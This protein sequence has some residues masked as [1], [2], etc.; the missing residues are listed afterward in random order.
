MLLRVIGQT[1]SAHPGQPIFCVDSSLRYNYK[2][3]RVYFSSSLL[4]CTRQASALR[5][6]C[7]S[8]LLDHLFWWIFLSWSPCFWLV[9]VHGKLACWTRGCDRC[10]VGRECV[11][12]VCVLNTC[13]LFFYFYWTGGVDRKS[14]V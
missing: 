11:D 4:I 9:V 13:M 10:L 7:G 12:V 8:S 5:R 1:P 14:I 2:A 6:A 3:M